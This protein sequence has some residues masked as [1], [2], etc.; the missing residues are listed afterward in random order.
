MV[1]EEPEDSLVVVDTDYVVV[2]LLD[3]WVAE[4]LERFWVDFLVNEGLEVCLV[5]AGAEYVVVEELENSL[6]A[7]DT[8]YVGVELLDLWVVEK[9]EGFLVVEET[10][11]ILADVGFQDCMVDLDIDIVIL[12]DFDL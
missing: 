10:V 5:V 12:E 11:D 8:D 9:F 3:L 1:A 4:E 7:V 6:V 2:E